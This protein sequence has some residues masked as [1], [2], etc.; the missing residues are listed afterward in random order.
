[1]EPISCGGC[2]GRNEDAGNDPIS[3]GLGAGLRQ[4][5]TNAGVT[6][7][8]TCHSDADPANYTPVGENVLPPNYFTPDPE[9][10]NQPTDPCN[11]HGQED[12]AGG[13]DGLD[14]DGDGRYDKRDRD[15][16]R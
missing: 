10:P 9:F 8:K 1:M 2:H 4:H 12:Y 15:C 6:E 5:H 7:C 14:N 13:R 3:A 11:R 16:R